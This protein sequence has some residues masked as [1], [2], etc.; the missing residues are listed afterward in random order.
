ML[1]LCIRQLVRSTFIPHH[2]TGVSEAVNHSKLE[3]QS[4]FFFLFIA[5]A[6][7]GKKNV[8]RKQKK[9]KE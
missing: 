7:I 4:T 6:G 3:I 2:S 5:I 8:E 1:T 9:R